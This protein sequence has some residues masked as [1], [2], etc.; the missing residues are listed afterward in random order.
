M[1]GENATMVALAGTIGISAAKV[2]AVF[3]SM[4]KSLI[5]V[6]DIVKDPN[7]AVPDDIAAQL[8]IMFQATDVLETQDELSKFMGFV[9]RI[10]SSEVQSVFFTMMMRS[11]PRVARYNA[12]ITEWATKNHMI[13]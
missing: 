7:M 13:M 6:K 2:M 5:N 4:E 3:M 12:K 1:L 8:M 11:K 9:E 10:P